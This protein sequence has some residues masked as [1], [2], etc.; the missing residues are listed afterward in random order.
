MTA[1]AMKTDRE[2]CLAAGMDGYLAK[3]IKT[4]EL[5]EMLE[6]RMM[7]RS[8]L[9]R[10]PS[11]TAVSGPQSVNA[12]ELLERLDGDRAFLAELTELF[13]ADY[14]RQ[15]KAI[16]EAIQHNDAAGV[17]QA[18]HA[19]KG[20]LSNLAASQAREIAAELERVGASGNLSAAGSNLRELEK[21]L[22]RTMES[23]D[24]L[25]QEIAS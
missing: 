14:P 3:P 5:D 19:L 13:R 21:E 24:S 11:R 22:T 7:Q 4:Q 1:L 6:A 16:S 25:C 18:S 17:K 15:V 20:A 2:R 10:A 23:L 8:T 12:D 9:R